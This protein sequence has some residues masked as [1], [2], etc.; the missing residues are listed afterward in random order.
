MRPWSGSSLK[1]YVFCFLADT[2]N[3]GTPNCNSPGTLR[4]SI[5]SPFSSFVVVE[6]VV[7]AFIVAAV[8]VEVITSVVGAEVVLDTIDGSD[9][10]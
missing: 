2:F 10:E 5:L 7:I 9:G 4:S 3:I 1:V 6:L 8:L